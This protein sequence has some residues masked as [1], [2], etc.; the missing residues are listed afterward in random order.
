MLFVCCSFLVGLV[1]GCHRVGLSYGFEDRLSY[2]IQKS[3]NLFIGRSDLRSNQ[4]RDLLYQRLTS[5]YKKDSTT[6]EVLTQS[7]ASLP[8]A[9]AC[10]PNQR[11]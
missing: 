8:M 9:L 3:F 1:T 10:H 11:P 7:S 6:G 4:S 2:Q 5:S